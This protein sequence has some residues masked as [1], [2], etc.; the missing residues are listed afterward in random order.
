[1]KAEPGYVIC[2][3]VCPLLDHCNCI[4]KCRLSLAYPYI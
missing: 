1:M 4:Y 3:S 2:K